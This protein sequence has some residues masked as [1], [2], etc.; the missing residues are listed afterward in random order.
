MKARRPAVNANISVLGKKDGWC[1]LVTSLGFPGTH[2]IKRSMSSGIT[3]GNKGNCPRCGEAF[4]CRP[5]DIG[6]CQCNQV[7]ISK[8]EYHYI[9][10]KFS[11][12]VCNACLRQL[13]NEFHQRIPR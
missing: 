2:A 13:K 9:S 4:V 5:H 3:S 10:S 7:L 12:C 1:R 11:D 6:N 8:E